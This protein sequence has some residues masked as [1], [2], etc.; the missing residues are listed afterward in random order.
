M[1]LVIGKQF[2]NGVPILQEAQI[3]VSKKGMILAVLLGF[4]MVLSL[5]AQQTVDPSVSNDSV[6]LTEP[7]ARF[8]YVGRITGTKVYIRSGPAE[9]YYPVGQFDL[10]QLVV[11]HEE[12]YGSWARVAPTSQKQ[13]L[14]EAELAELVG[15]EIIRGQVT[16]NRGR[17][18]AGSVDIVPPAHASE[19]QTKC[20]M[21]DEVRVIGQR[22]NFYKI[23]CPAG[24]FFWAALDYIE[25]ETPATKEAIDQVQQQEAAAAE[26][27]KTAAQQTEQISK[28]RQEYLAAV[29]MLQ[30]EQAKPMAQ[31]DYQPI[32]ER[33][34]KLLDATASPA[35]KSTGQILLQQ[36]ARCETGLNLWKLSHQQNAQLKETLTKINQD[37]QKVELL[38]AAQSAVGA[39][40]D[41]IVVK[42]LL[43]KS[44]VF[45]A[46]N[47]N[48][49]FLVLDADNRI[50]YYA[51]AA[52]AGLDLSG[53]VGKKV[54]MLGQA[55]YDTITRI[56]ILK[57]TNI[58]EQT[59]EIKGDK[60]ADDKIIKK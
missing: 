9:V 43:E 34:E 2:H 55:Q 40:P 19:V 15:K 54:S 25:S 47:K 56:R 29:E 24:C 18:R 60:K 35:V 22:D 27:Q 52:K 30:L 26:E 4:V 32:R 8:P 33:L 48:L 6:Q 23:E 16:G 11:V 58:V 42:G 53:Y 59:S 14:T 1:V 49:R 41:G 57:V 36:L 21:G 10:G 45:T 17:V 50:I 12:K 3:M 44:A 39:T 37:R 51:V 20:N 7:T 28:D 5:W 38:V 13:T 31:R 46:E